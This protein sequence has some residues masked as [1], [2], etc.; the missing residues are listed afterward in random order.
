MRITSWRDRVPSWVWTFVRRVVV[1]LSIMTWLACSSPLIA[2]GSTKILSSGAPDERGSHGEHGDRVCAVEP[3]V[4]NDYHGLGRVDTSGRRPDF[5]TPHSSSQSVNSS[6]K[7]WSSSAAGLLA[8]R[9]D[10][11]CASRSKPGAF[12]SGTQIWMGRSPCA[13]SRARWLRT[14]SLMRV[15]MQAKLHV[16]RASWRRDNV[17]R[18]GE[19]PHQRAALYISDT[20]AGGAWPRPRR[21][22]ASRC[23]STTTSTQ[24]RGLQPLTALCGDHQARQ[25]VRRRHRRRRGRRLPQGARVRPGQRVRRGDRGEPAGASL[26]MSA[27]RAGRLGRRSL[28]R[29]AASSGESTSADRDQNSIGGSL[30]AARSDVINFSPAATARHTDNAE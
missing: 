8:T 26:R 29:Q 9:V 18:Y 30:T 1:T 16:T 17:L 19:N 2:D 15:T 14:R 4:L 22:P 10:W 6:T 7:A 3:V 11:R 20:D 13:R 5:A 24:T 21:C 27:S 23:R 28:S 25:P 12:T